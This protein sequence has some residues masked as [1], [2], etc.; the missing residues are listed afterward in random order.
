MIHFFYKANN[1]NDN[2]KIIS[3]GGAEGVTGSCFFIETG[4]TRLLV[5]CG[6]FQGDE[7]N[8]NEKPFPF[9]PKRLDAVF[10]THAHLD[11]SGRLPLLVKQG[12]KGRIICTS[13]TADLT[14]IILLDAAKIMEEDYHVQLKKALRRGEKA[15]APLYNDD[16]VA[17]TINLFYPWQ[18]NNTFHLNGNV[19]V[20]LKDAGHILG[21][22]FVEFTVIEDGNVKNVTFSG[23]L[24]NRNKPIVR[25]PEKP[26]DTDILF[27]ESTYGDREH[28]NFEDTYREFENAIHYAFSR[29]GNIIIPSFALERAQE[30]IYILRELYIKKSLPPCRVFL[31]SPLAIHATNLFRK[32]LEYFDEEAQIITKKGEDPFYFPYL[33]FSKTTED[34]KAINNIKGR[35]IIIAGSGMCNGG[36]ILHHLKHNLWNENNCI[37]FVGFQARG[38]LGRQIVDGEKVVY[39]YGEPINVN[40]KVC[41]INGFSSHADKKILKNWISSISSLK[42]L[43]LIH[44]ENWVK[45]SFKSELEQ[46]FRFPVNTVK[47]SEEILL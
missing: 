20:T 38:T 37:I 24:G 23:D 44:G 47:E 21:S 41:T 9:D 46:E 17:R 22:A 33:I 36:R 25:D 2:M 11:H 30:L 40:A 43:Y 6:F 45:Q 7:N 29:G 15:K 34:S 10:L 1:P 19:K 13:V 31:D 28:R 18:Y 32:H 39:I 26:S 8:R 16:D 27:I 14:R 35:A 4:D 3:Y 42:Q 5:D 12:F